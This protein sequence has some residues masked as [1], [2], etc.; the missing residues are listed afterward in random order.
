MNLPQHLS[1]PGVLVPQEAVESK[2]RSEELTVSFTTNGMGG[3][4]LRQA[5]RPAP[6]SRTVALVEGNATSMTFY[7]HVKSR[8]FYIP[9]LT[10]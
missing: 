8:I 9:Q 6:D 1:V 10:D 3:I 2:P 7:I 5:L 4:P